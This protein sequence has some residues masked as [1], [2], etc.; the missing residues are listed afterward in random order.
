MLIALKKNGIA[1]ILNLQNERKRFME[2]FFEC[3]DSLSSTVDN[4]SS[5][6]DHVELSL[7]ATKMSKII[8]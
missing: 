2:K 3:F 1:L 8:F 6:L 7:I 4:S 5:K